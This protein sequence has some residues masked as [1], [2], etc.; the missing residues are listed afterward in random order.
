MGRDSH[1]LTINSGSSSIKFSLYGLGETEAL[2][3][4]GELA[5]I[6]V[7]R[8]YFQAEDQGGHQP[9]ARKIELPD[10]DAAWKAL[11]DWLQ[12]HEIGKDLHAVGHR[13]VQGGA[14]HVK[15]QISSPA[16]I[17]DLKLLMPLAP[18]HLPHEIKGLEAVHRHYPRLPQVVCFDTAFHRRMPEVAQRYALPEPL[19]QAGLQ[20]YGF[21]GLS[22]EYLT[23]ELERE[24]ES[25]E[26]YGKLIIAHLGNGAS[27]AAIKD[28]RSLDTTM[29][30]TPA[31]GLVMG[32]RVGDLDPG[33]ILYLL[34]EKGMSPAVVN[35]LVNH[36][37]GLLGISGI[38]EDMRDL[39]AREDTAT[40]AALA[41]GVFCYQAR[42]FIGALAAVLGGLD[43]FIFTGGIGENSATIRARICANLEFLG[44]HLDPNLN[45]ENAPIISKK[46]SPVTVR[47]MKTN[48][49]LMIARHTRGLLTG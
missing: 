45:N 27:M 11:F 33:V 42:K 18:D 7:E 32:T 38:S 46:G 31:G 14:A 35:H 23:Q 24:A 19:F 49:E 44:I 40:G 28:G 6:G 43:T 9:T 36:Q 12:G 39:L 47:V 16:L 2:I 17:A 22:Y 5:G 29:G 15:P 48:E 10:H 13:L 30:L 41:V 4:K 26:A 34:Q 37:A 21:H 25:Q 8:G 3:L 20:R 1:I